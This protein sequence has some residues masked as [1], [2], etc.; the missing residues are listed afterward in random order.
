VSNLTTEPFEMNSNGEPVCVRLYEIHAKTGRA[1]VGKCANNCCAVT[2]HPHKGKLFRLDL[3][4]GSNAGG[5]ECK[6]EYLWLCSRCALEMH[7][8]VVVT[9]NTISV[10]L[11]RNPATAATASSERLN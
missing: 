8:K 4:I 9:G 2:R 11:A 5:D 6:T 7:P 1:M 3:E 10:R